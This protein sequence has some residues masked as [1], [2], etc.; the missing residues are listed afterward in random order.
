[1]VKQG[2]IGGSN[3]FIVNGFT[4]I[5]IRH[6]NPCLPASRIQI[7]SLLFKFTHHYSLYRWKRLPFVQIAYLKQHRSKKSDTELPAERTLF[8]ANC[9][10]GEED[11]R[12]IF[13]RF[14]D[15][16]R[17]KLGEFASKKMG[18]PG[19]DTLS[20]FVHGPVGEKH[21][22]I[23]F[24]SPSAVRAALACS[25]IL[26]DDGGSSEPTDLLSMVVSAHRSRNVSADDLQASVDSHLAAFD[27]RSEAEKRLRR[28]GLIDE[29][30]FQLVTY[31]RKNRH[32]DPLTVEAPSKKKKELGDFYRFQIREKKR[33]GHTNAFPHISGLPLIWRVPIPPSFFGG[34]QASFSTLPILP[35]FSCLFTR[36]PPAAPITAHSAGVGVD[37]VSV[38]AW[39][40]WGGGR[41]GGRAG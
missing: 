6:A 2:K 40:V 26:E 31:K 4:A 10:M 25:E 38:G 37:G 32:V 16:E 17:V 20:G 24:E 29:D 33:C 39:L 22:H 9:N 15:I 7:H 8:V 21:A 23:V 11:I 13:S 36:C 28:E 18:Y 5:R 19:K 30:G 1:M 41:A 12:L 3:A 27:E 34:R 14:G 35:C